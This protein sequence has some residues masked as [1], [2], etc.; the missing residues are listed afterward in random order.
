M[1]HLSVND[2]VLG[3]K[4]ILTRKRTLVYFPYISANSFSFF[5]LSLR[6]VRNLYHHI[7]IN[8]R[9]NFLLKLIC[10]IPAKIPPVTKFF[11]ISRIW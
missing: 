4:T 1:A 5:L 10:F 8:F 7:C 2:T 11:L 3:I 9:H 6:A